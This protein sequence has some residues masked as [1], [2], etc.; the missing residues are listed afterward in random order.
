MFANNYYSGVKYFENGG[1]TNTA[2]CGADVLEMED[3]KMHAI[4]N[5]NHHKV[6]SSATDNN[7]VD[8][9]DQ[10]NDLTLNHNYGVDIQITKKHMGVT[11]LTSQNWARYGGNNDHKR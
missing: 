3:S 10:N 8:D 9:S 5:D 2:N 7:N 6:S 4:S 1:Q 11:R